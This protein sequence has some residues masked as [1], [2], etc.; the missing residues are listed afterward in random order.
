MVYMRNLAARGR[1]IRLQFTRETSKIAIDD[2][3]YSAVVIDD[4]SAKVAICDK[5]MVIR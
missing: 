1:R 2:M 3:S 5:L 4:M